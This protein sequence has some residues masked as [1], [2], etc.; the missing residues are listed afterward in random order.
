MYLA[1]NMTNLNCLKLYFSGPVGV[2][3]YHGFNVETYSVRVQ[4]NVKGVF[5]R[6]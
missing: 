6:Q 4:K 3:C 1:R 5:R 2:T